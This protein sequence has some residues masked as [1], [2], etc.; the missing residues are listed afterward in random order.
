VLT[1]EGLEALHKA[2]AL[3][4]ATAV[5]HLRAAHHYVLAA[6]LEPRWATAF[7]LGPD[8]AVMHLEA[9]HHYVLAAN[10][11]PRWKELA[12]HH[13]RQAIQ[14]GIK[15]EQVKNDTILKRRLE[16]DPGF[17]ELL[18]MPSVAAPTNLLTLQAVQDPLRDFPPN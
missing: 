10:L 5:M 17:L 6:N 14:G 3:G 13:L 4:P 2:F 8:T 18:Q 11:E 7:A 9:A 12:L 15:T 1:R 16:K